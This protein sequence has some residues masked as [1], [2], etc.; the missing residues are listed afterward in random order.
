MN[1]IFKINESQL[2]LLS[3]GTDIH[4][5]TGGVSD[6]VYHVAHKKDIESLFE[7][8]FDREYTNSNAGNAY[9]PGVY[10]TYSLRSSQ[11]NMTHGLYGS[12][13]LELVIKDGFNNFLIFDEDIAKKYYGSEYRIEN[14][15]KKLM[16]Q[17]YDTLINS[18]KF[19]MH[20]LTSSDAYFIWTTLRNRLNSTNVRGFIFTGAHDGN[21]AVIRDFNSAIPNKYSN[22]G[23]KTW[24]TGF[25]EKIAN[26]IEKNVD[27]EFKYGGKFDKM[28]KSV[29]GFVRVEKGGKINYIDIKTDKLISNGWFDF[30][31]NFD[32]DGK[33]AEVSY[34]GETYVITPTELLDSDYFPICGLDELK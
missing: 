9:G 25:N 8:G 18:H 33:F 4:S 22:D 20:G 19:H 16:P 15:I 32:S 31:S 27:A 7:Y 3:E 6:K 26:R 21:V 11:K 24:E 23:G 10:S 13:I 29:G 2:Q 17:Y 30:G 12:V 34:K 14:Q 5:L 1:K 28:S